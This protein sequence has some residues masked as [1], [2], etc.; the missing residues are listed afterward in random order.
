M[1]YGQFSCSAYSKK[2]TFRLKFAQILRIIEAELNLPDAYKKECI[3]E[4]F[5]CSN[6]LQHLKKY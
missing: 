5:E 4:I 2:H 3:S 1:K 6:F